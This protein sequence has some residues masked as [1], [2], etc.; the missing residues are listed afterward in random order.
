[1]QRRGVTLTEVLVAVF[2]LGLSLVALMTLFPLGA[3]NMAQAIQDDRAAQCAANAAALLRTSWRAAVDNGTVDVN[4]E[5]T[6]ASNKAVYFDP[7]GAL[8]FTGA[9]QTSV[10]GAGTMPRAGVAGLNLTQAQRWFSL[11]DEMTFNT[12]GTLSLTGNSAS[13]R[14]DYSWAYVL[15]MLGS[16]NPPVGGQPAQYARALDY[17]VVVYKGRPF[18]S[19]AGLTPVGETSVGV[20]S[21][22]AGS[23]SITFAGLPAT[24]KKGMWV[25][26]GTNGYFYQ[27][28]G[29]NG[30]I[31]EVNNPIRVGFATAVIIDGVVNVFDRSTLE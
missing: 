9:A 25:L 23:T 29:V 22:T 17:S 1:M 7:Y 16:P 27:A 21:A 4:L 30:N 5:T 8:S 28:T 13:R 24:F 15:R 3:S 2:V 20:S 11:L 6:L 26:D 10:A 19:T 12:N 31:V 14:P 18:A